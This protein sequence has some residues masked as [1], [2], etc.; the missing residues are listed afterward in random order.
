MTKIL[1]ELQSFVCKEQSGVTSWHP[2]FGWFKQSVDSRLN[3]SSLLVTK[4]L[5]ILWKRSTIELLFQFLPPLQMTTEKKAINNKGLFNII[6]LLSKS[7]SK[8]SWRYFCPTIFLLGK[9]STVPTHPTTT[10]HLPYHHLPPPTA[11]THLPTTTTTPCY[12]HTPSYHHHTHN[13][14]VTPLAVVFTWFSHKLDTT[15]LL[16]VPFL[17]FVLDSR[18]RL[19]ARLITERFSSRQVANLSSPEVVQTCNTCVLFQLILTSFSQL[20]MDVLTGGYDIKHFSPHQRVYTCAY[21]VV[22]NILVRH[23]AFLCGSIS[24]PGHFAST[25]ESL[26]KWPWHQA[27]DS[28]IWLVTYKNSIRWRI[29]YSSKFWTL[30]PIFNDDF[31]C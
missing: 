20:R 3:T 21:V 29:I 26:R 18:R 14:V 24:Y 22:S 25:V 16:F 28:I 27:V 13:L 2:I 1:L 15:R 10:T 4:Q 9:T 11:T 6:F 8:M 23:L 7:F 5:Q 19:L 12:H 30:R 31:K 17:K